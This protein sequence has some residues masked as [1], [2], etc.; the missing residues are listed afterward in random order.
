MAYVGRGTR[1]ESVCADQ[2]VFSREGASRGQGRGLVCR[3]TGETGLTPHPTG[4]ATVSDNRTPRAI[5]QYFQRLKYICTA[6][7]SAGKA[8]VSLLYGRAAFSAP[9]GRTAD[10]LGACLPHRR[11]VR[12]VAAPGLVHA[13]SPVRGFGL[14]TPKRRCLGGGFKLDPS[15]LSVVGQMIFMTR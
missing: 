9:R 10:P 13:A 7:A 15:G 6:D 3:T 4:S 1:L 12:P 14:P 2:T 5:Q 11:L 8:N